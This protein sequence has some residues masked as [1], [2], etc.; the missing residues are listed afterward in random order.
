MSEMSLDTK[1]LEKKRKKVFN[2][3]KKNMVSLGTYRKEFDVIIKRYAEI[4]MQFDILNEKWYE[5]G[6]RVTEKYTNKAG[7]TND[8]KTALYLASEKIRD[9]LADMENVFG[10][11]PKG[12]KALKKKGLDQQKQSAL[13]KMLSG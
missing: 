7:A 9:E 3:T 4:R 11:T 12:L 6:C 13:D 2:E 5:D 8:R 1:T 10:L